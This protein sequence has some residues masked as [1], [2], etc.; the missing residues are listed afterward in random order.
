M[1]SAN[2]T[3]AQ[4]L[5]NGLQIDHCKEI[6]YKL[7]VGVYTCNAEGYIELYNE[8][9]VQLWG[10]TPEA[11]KEKWCGSWKMY[12]TD[13]TLLPHDECPMAMAIKEGR[14]V[15]NEIIVEQ[16]DGT[17]Y[18]VIPHTQP[19]RDLS[20]NITGAVNTVIDITHL[21]EA[22]KKIEESEKRYNMM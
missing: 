14:T 12:N 1:K 19:L 9:A 16:P 2:E 11:G 17:R 3:P 6:L 8:A 7:P 13:G 10:R 21:A 15:R 4:E 18:S 22:R 20:G 5:Q